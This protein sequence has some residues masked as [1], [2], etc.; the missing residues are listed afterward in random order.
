MF[1][2]YIVGVMFGSLFVSA[3]AAG[4]IL[5]F[6]YSNKPWVCLLIIGISLIASIYYF[7][8]L[9]GSFIANLMNYPERI[10]PNLVLLI[11]VV[12]IITF[13][14]C[15]VGQMNPD[16]LVALCVFF[17]LILVLFVVYPTVK[18]NN[19]IYTINE[20]VTNKKEID[21]NAPYKIIEKKQNNHN[22]YIKI[23]MNDMDCDFF[24]L[25]LHS[26]IKKHAYFENKSGK[27]Y[28][29]G[30]EFY[31]NNKKYNENNQECKK[32]D[33]IISFKMI[34]K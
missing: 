11:C 34:E 26:K 10:V 31:L 8:D 33:N 30:E 7:H 18:S 23:S 1:L 17:I 20:V 2:L 19:L 3:L 15:F 6:G 9:K 12:S 13:I 29:I 21:N 4:T 16:W 24:I 14:F 27:K 32:G 25:N 5:S 22:Y 28:L